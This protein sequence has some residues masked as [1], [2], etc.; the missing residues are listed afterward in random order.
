M[1][2]PV[3]YSHHE[4]A[5]SQ[6]E[7]HLRY[8]DALSMA[9]ALMTYKLVVKEI[10]IKHGVYASFMP[11]PIAG[12]NGSGMH[13]HQSLFEGDSNA[14]FDPDDEFG[15]SETAKCYIAG[16]LKYAPEFTL[17]TNQYVNSYKRLIPGFEAPVYIAWSARNRSSLVRV[18]RYK[19]GKEGAARFELRSPD[20]ACNP[21][22]VFAVLLG[23]GL[24]GIEEGLVLGPPADD[25]Q[26]SGRLE[27][28]EQAGIAT[29]PTNLGSA[30][31]LFEQS[32]LM[33]E[34]LGEQLHRF[35]VENKRA[36]WKEYCAQV[37]QWEISRDYPVL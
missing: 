7:I 27:A 24:K 1:G 11:K 17:L 19:P 36:E 32:E 20:P 28:L 9:D 12:I 22:L 5:P 26:L 6:Q 33:K 4:S 18:P 8:S 13:V 30:T 29:L 35:I 21:Y 10:A 37:T 16:Q 2:I 3:E 23:A 14:F 31:K 34:I 25:E 15:L